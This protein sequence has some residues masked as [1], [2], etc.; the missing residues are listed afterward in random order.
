MK[1]TVIAALAF[2]FMACSA[3]QVTKNNKS[4]KYPETNKG[5]VE[6]S[7]FGTT[8]KD[9]YRWLEDDLSD[10]TKSWV[11]AQNKVTNAYLEQ[12]PFRN[13]IKEQMTDLWNYEKISSP[14]KEGNWTYFYKN[15]G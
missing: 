12:I 13:Q 4:L 10:E 14:F 2:T 8:I 5:N 3:Q 9:P 11:Q 1:K 7:H 15:D 6:Y